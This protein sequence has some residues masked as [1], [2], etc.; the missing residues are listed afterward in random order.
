MSRISSW[1]TVIYTIVPE[2]VAAEQ[3]MN[4]CQQANITPD[5][6]RRFAAAGMLV[7]NNKGHQPP[8]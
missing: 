6:L 5:L 2:E 3:Q 4:L 8:L 7:P 1:H